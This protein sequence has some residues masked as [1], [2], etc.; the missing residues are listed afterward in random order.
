MQNLVR[1]KAFISY[2]HRD[3]RHLARLHVH[4]AY[5]KRCGLLD[6]WDDMKV[7]PGA[8]WR[9]EINNVNAIMIEGHS[10]SEK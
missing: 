3:A 7:L 10:L 5:Y 8:I 4:L 6:V 1:T 9:E 2:C